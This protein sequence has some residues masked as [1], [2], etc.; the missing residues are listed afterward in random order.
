MR[1]YSCI[2]M[3]ACMFLAFPQQQKIYFD[4]QIAKHLKAYRAKSE[5]AIQNGDNIYAGFLF[6]S[7]FNNYLKHSYIR[8]ISLS[9]VKGGSLKTSTLDKPF[10]LITKSSWEQINL[11]EINEINRM[12]KLYKDQIDIIIL[13]WDSKTKA[14]ALSKNYNSNVIIT[15]VDERKNNSNYI[16]ATFKH[17]FGAPACFYISE[18]KQLVRIDKKFTIVK[19][20]NR[21]EVAFNVIHEKIKW[22][23]FKEEPNSEGLIISTVN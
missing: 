16:I 18:E 21:S 7:I 15:Y 8:D 11:E 9:K 17:S 6:D 1:V 19:D 5:V 23:L 3:F 13:F 22:M 4:T 14:K 10:L 2:L 20:E 12:S